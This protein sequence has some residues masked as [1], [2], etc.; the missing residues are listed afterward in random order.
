MSL[1]RRL[2]APPATWERDVDVVVLG[3]GAAGLSAALAVRPVRSV[4]VVTK[5]ILSA[6]STQWA[7][8][9]LAGVLDPSDSIEDWVLPTGTVPAVKDKKDFMERLGKAVTA[10]NDKDQSLLTWGYHPAFFGPLT[11]A[12]LDGISTRT[13]RAALG[14]LARILGH[15]HGDAQGAAG[16]DDHHVLARPCLARAVVEVHPEPVQMDG[17]VHHG[18]VLEDQAHRFA[19]GEV[20]DRLLGVFAVIERPDELLHVACQPQLDRT[21]GLRQP[22]C[23]VLAPGQPGAALRNPLHTWRGQATRHLPGAGP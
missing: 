9:G 3:S 14:D 5:D 1:P 15:G 10:L 22:V 16:R 13:A 18:L 11:R 8:G 17:V 19:L 23:S 12:E 21:I 2:A 4:L 6:G 7:Q 20:E